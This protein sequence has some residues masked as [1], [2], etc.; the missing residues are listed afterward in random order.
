MIRFGPFDLVEPLGQGGMA[1]VWRGRHHTHG[2]EVAIKIITSRLAHQE[3]YQRAFRAEIQAAAKLLHPGIVL[4]LDEG[5]VP[6]GAKKEGMIE[7]SPYFAMELIEGGTLKDLRGQFDWPTTRH[8]LRQILEALASAHASG[9]I[10]RDLK[11]ANILIDRS[12]KIIRPRITDFGIAQ[13]LDSDFTPTTSPSEQS[14]TGTPKYMAPEQIAGTWRDQG[15]WTDLYAIGC[16]AFWMITGNVPFDEESVYATLRSHVEARIPALEPRFAIPEGL[17]DWVGNLL[18]KRPASRFQRAADAIWA[19]ERLGSATRMADI[20]QELSTN[21]EQATVVLDDESMPTRIITGES[22]RISGEFDPLSLAEYPPPAPPIPMSWSVREDSRPR[23]LHGAGLGL[24]AL[25]PVPLVGR[26][27]ER[28]VLWRALVETHQNQDARAIIVRG[29]SGVG[30]SRLIEWFAEHADEVGAA[31]VL[32]ARHGEVHGPFDGVSGMLARELR[33]VG[34]SSESL[35]ER[36]IKRLRRTRPADAMVPY[37]ANVLATIADTQHDQQEARQPVAPGDRHAALGRWIE[38]ESHTRPLLFWIDDAQWGWDVLGFVLDA[39][40]RIETPALFVLT[41]RDDALVERPREAARL[42]KLEQMPSCSTITLDSLG[43]DDHELLVA[44]LLGLDESLGTAIARRT[45]GNPLFAVQFVGS[46]VERGLLV[47]S[48]SGFVLDGEMP[49]IP[50]DLHQVWIERTE[51]VLGTLPPRQRA[52]GWRALEIAAC[53]GQEVSLP[54]WIRATSVERLTPP[55]ALVERMRRAHLFE[56]DAEAD[57]FSFVHAMLRESLE[58]HARERGA[59]ASAHRTCARAL[60]EETNKGHVRFEPNACARLAHHLIMANDHEAALAPLL[61]AAAR[62][63]EIDDLESAAS[64]L[65]QRR[66]LFEPLGVHDEHPAWLENEIIEGWVAVRYAHAEEGTRLAERVLAIAERDG[67]DALLGKALRLLGKVLRAHSMDDSS[68]AF[69]RALIPLARAGDMAELGKAKLALG[70]DRGR[71]GSVEE[72]LGIL[73]EAQL[74][75]QRTGDL[76]WEKNITRARSFLLLQGGRLK[77]AREAS[78]QAL[79]WAKTSGIV[80]EIVASHSALAEVLRYQ[81]HFEEAREHYLMRDELGGYSD[82]LN[83]LINKFNLSLVELGLRNYEAADALL[84]E[85]SE[86]LDKLE[87][88]VMVMFFVSASIVTHAAFGRWESFDQDLAAL[89]ERRQ[90]SKLI[91]RDVVWCLERASYLA[92]KAGHPERAERAKTLSEQF[93]S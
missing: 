56:V 54:E 7:G 6:A 45:R 42:T 51:Y 57:E 52:E 20:S 84:D 19:L 33:C 11:P 47:T 43:E 76:F 16:L 25:R 37:D 14:V 15:P 60:E 55:T 58:R 63:M 77:E 80:S 36:T 23:H 88:V 50:D 75:F 66:A 65:E 12:G 30:K 5:Q 92:K 9:V 8:L 44:H 73:D 32:R 59:L 39:L 68:A 64:F 62:S 27:R 72:G 31:R 24:Y 18:Q 41:V 82:A 79:E 35:R 40:E 85:L 38:G 1:S 87:Q 4:I 91:D 17:E 90:T 34:E 71:S 22:S 61:Q 81:G 67:H 2:T 46:L 83:P 93:Q 89:D 78:E 21:L 86:S 13:A 10:H 69:E 3:R 70:W 29:P 74:V 53:L 49:S 28:D 48:E 26:Q